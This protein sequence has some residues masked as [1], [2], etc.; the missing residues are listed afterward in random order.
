MEA[1][2]LLDS[3]TKPFLAATLVACTVFTPVE[4]Q[5]S[6]ESYYAAA[7]L[8]YDC[9]NL[10]EARRLFLSALKYARQCKQDAKLT[11]RLESLAEF[12]VQTDRRAQAE[13]LYK[14]LKKL[15]TKQS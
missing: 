10:L 8:A 12:Y 9:H 11:G 3:L 4:A 15:R 13:P 1:L 14:L 5:E 7:Q 6:W 2:I